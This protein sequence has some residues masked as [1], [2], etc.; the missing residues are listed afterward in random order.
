MSYN[1][2]AI[3]RSVARVKRLQKRA[4]RRRRI[5]A[6]CCGV[7][8]ITAAA[9][10]LCGGGADREYRETT[11]TVHSGDTLWEIASEY[12]PEDMDKRKYIH[13]IQDD[14]GCGADIRSGDVLT[15]RVYDGK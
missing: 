3:E 2:K 6:V 11:V 9:V 1:D 7:A 14:N 12:C 10:L 13:I 8:A 5:T 15:V 4:E